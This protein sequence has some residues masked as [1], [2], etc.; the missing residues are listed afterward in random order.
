[1]AIL[2]RELRFLLKK[3]R[4]VRT[5]AE[6]DVPAWSERTGQEWGYLHQQHY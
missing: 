6:A 4:E 3:M 2:Y 5:L 1:M